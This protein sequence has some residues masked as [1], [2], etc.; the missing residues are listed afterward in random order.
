MN[1]NGLL[2]VLPDWGVFVPFFRPAVSGQY[3]GYQLLS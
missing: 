3:F 1:C 2:Q